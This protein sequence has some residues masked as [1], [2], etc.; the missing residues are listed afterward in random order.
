MKNPAFK[1][2]ATQLPDLPPVPGKHPTVARDHE[3]TRYGTLSILA[4][5]DLHDGHVIVRVEERYRSAEFIGLL[6]QLDAWYPAE[7]TIRIILDNHSA[8]LSKQTRDW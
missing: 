1:P 5:L 3:Y 2:S 6:N 7:C 4:S 8:H